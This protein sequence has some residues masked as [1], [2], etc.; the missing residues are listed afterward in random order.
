MPVYEYHCPV[1]EKRF[2]AFK[3]LANYA[4]E[5][6]HTCGAVAQKVVSLPMVAVDYPAYV[7]PASGRVVEGKKAH[8]EEL[9]RTNC[10]LLEPGERQDAVKRKKAEEKKFDK[11]VDNGV[12]RVFAELKGV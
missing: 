1:C 4:D 9:K 2:D 8:L 5:Q 3:K 11:L 10:R 7:S 12:D 6:R